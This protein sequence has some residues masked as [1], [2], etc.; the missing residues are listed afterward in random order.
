MADDITLNAGTGGDTVAAD[1]IAGIKYPRVKLV[2][3][4]NNTNDGDV[5]SGNPLPVSDAG[6][7]LTV[8]GT[9]A[10]TQSG[11]WNVG[12][13]TT[14]ST[15]TNVVHVDDNSSTL[16]V[17]DGAGS[18]TVDGTVTA[19]LQD[20]SGNAITSTASALDVN[21]KSGSSSGTQYTEDAVAAANPVGD[22]LILVREDARAGSLTTT[23]GDN[24]AAR[25]T[26]AGELYVKHVD[27]IP[28]TDNSGS[29]TVDGSVTAN[30]GTNL[31]TS[32]LA[33]ETGGNLA[34]VAA[35]SRAEDA[36]HSSGHTGVMLLA[37]REATATDLSAGATD[38]DY[39][40]L[41]VSASGRLWASATIDAALPAGTN[42]IGKL[43]ANSGV[44]IG[45]V[46]VAAAQTLATVTTVS[47]VT[48]L[49]TLTG[50]AVAHDGADSGNPIK[51]GAKCSLTLSDDTIVANA[52]RT[53]LTSDGDGAVLV[54]PQFP[55]ADLIS[56]AISDTGGSSTAFSNF[57]ATASTRSVITFIHAYRTDAGTSPAYVDFRDGTGGSVLF[58]AVL[59]PNGG[60]VLSNGGSPLF[61]TTANTALAYDVSAALTTVYIS[62]S[63]FKS[64]V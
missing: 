34:T 49:S 64:K 59:P 14:V 20:G 4:A 30:A 47:T 33:L 28:V 63:G 24:V 48:T 46:E 41:Q 52:D 16:S 19:K 15:I 8:D 44:T 23:D 26:N 21:I 27:A 29:L 3:G 7:S 60:S 56:E 42:A 6:G 51:V 25:G 62:V 53:D 32:A 43:A 10:A 35:L 39:E 12:T 2:L 1:D 22:A 50:G 17:D 58:R 55:L 61:R 40:P 13:V 5:A 37:V 54:R 38:G 9:V 18:L 11:T 57:G 45:A 36:A 31:N